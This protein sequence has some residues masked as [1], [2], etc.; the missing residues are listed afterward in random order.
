MSANR[1]KQIM[2]TA[3]IVLKLFF[4]FVF[5]HYNEHACA[6]CG[7]INKGIMVGVLSRIYIEQYFI[8]D[9]QGKVCKT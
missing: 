7:Y 2:K 5:F 6:M 9:A 3:S 1:L 8:F 4:L